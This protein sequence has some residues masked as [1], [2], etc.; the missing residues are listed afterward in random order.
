M[1]RVC[2]QYMGG[3]VVYKP[4]TL[5]LIY[6]SFLVAGFLLMLTYNYPLVRYGAIVVM[7]VTAVINRRRI[8]KVIGQIMALRKKKHL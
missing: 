1:R 5:L 6:G 7:L 4:S 3:V 8:T 2:N